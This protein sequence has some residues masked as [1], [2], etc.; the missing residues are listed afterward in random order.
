MLLCRRF[1]TVP[2]CSTP[3]REGQR[4]TKASLLNI[5]SFERVLLMA[6]EDA[7]QREV[8]RRELDDEADASRLRALALELYDLWQRQRSVTNQLVL[9]DIRQS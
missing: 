6:P 8:F 4:H 7:F 1:G 3:S 9:Q 5:C 2:T